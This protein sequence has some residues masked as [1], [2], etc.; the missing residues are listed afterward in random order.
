MKRFPSVAPES[1]GG[2]T[3]RCMEKKKT[4]STRVAAAVL[5]A[6]LGSAIL[7]VAAFTGVAAK[8]FIDTENT[9][10]KQSL[11]RTRA[12]LER[13]LRSMAILASACADQDRFRPPIGSAT[14]DLSGDAFRPMITELDVDFVALFSADGTA[15]SITERSAATTAAMRE[16][17]RSE[18]RAV[19]AS[20]EARAVFVLL[21]GSPYALAAALARGAAADGKG[22]PPG[23]TLVLGR[24]VD[25]RFAGEISDLAGVAVRLLP[26]GAEI[27]SLPAIVRASPSGPVVGRSVLENAEGVPVLVIETS[28][29]TTVLERGRRFFM[30]FIFVALFILAAAFL[31]VRAS[32]HIL[33]VKPIELMEASLRASGADP[34]GFRLE[35]ERLRERNDIVGKTA[36]LM[37]EVDA[38]LKRN[39]E[40]ELLATE[41]LEAEVRS[42]TEEIVEAKSALEVYK[43][44]MEETSEGIAITD[45]RGNVLEVNGAYCRLSGYAREELLGQNSSMM[46]SGKHDEAF[47]QRMWDA[48]LA[49]G[50]WEGEMWDKRKD[51]TL[52]PKWLSVDTIRDAAGAPERYV[53]IAADITRMKE[54]EANLNRLAFY[55][56]LTGLPNRSLFADRFMQALTRAQRGH[57]RVALLYLDLDHFKDVN[58]GYGHHAGDELLCKAAAR[59]AAQVREADTVCRIGGD[60]FTVILESIKKSDDAAAVARK[61]VDV[62]REPFKLRDTVV[63]VG[64]SVGIALYPYDGIGFEDLVKHADA[65]MYEAKEHG[66]S[67]YRFASGGAGTTSRRRIE[68]ETRLR[69]AIA[70]NGFELYYQPQVSAGGAAVGS[71]AGLVGAEAL[72]RLRAEDG[73][74]IEPGLFIEAAEE[75]GLIVQIGAWV[76]REA[77]R[78]AKRWLDAG[79]EV[80]VSVNVSPR[81]FEQGI[82]VDQ[83]AAALEETGL[84]PRLLRLE[85]TE[86]LFLRDGDRN[87]AIIRSLKSLGVTF[88]V[89][90]F[91]VN[92]S[93]LRYIDTIPID[94]LKI[95]RAFVRSIFSRF[96]GGDVATAVI[97]LARSFG[98]SSVAEGVETSGQLD[99][100]RARGCDEVQGYYVSRPLDAA[101]FRAY[102]AGEL[103]PPPAEGEDDAAALEE[104]L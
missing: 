56:S 16:T 27:G 61:I 11:G 93:S 78:E 4:L 38:G 98:L 33:L 95:D 76:L 22:A 23:G 44:I 37:I 103:T 80:P 59:I 58:D 43:R 15:F 94:S 6:S 92:Y 87:A 12:I 70:V 30:A 73:S 55:D 64:A 91:G 71:N 57:T 72:V 46:Q 34:G 63:Y 39:L 7:I 104:V 17:I 49:T 102:L 100:I 75:T 21:D 77:S 99:A 41:R 10:T 9:L 5:A 82:I 53:W 86:S 20:G 26:S 8:G 47:Y 45:L 50:R 66:R 32:A 2:Y 88:S 24:A 84:P 68:M 13:R 74:L 28:E 19:A 18:A 60:E 52:F 79:K 36:E 40:A 48:I 42:R 85:V 67:Q 89:D 96:D 14:P 51:G 97:A 101:N 69:N 3:C 35:L 29:P 65:A 62:L 1:G 25:E 54:T 81:Q 90:D 83:V 31:G